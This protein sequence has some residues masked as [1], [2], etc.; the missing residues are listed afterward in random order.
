[1]SPGP[2]TP[3]GEE[4]RAEPEIL[5]PLRGEARGEAMWQSADDH[6]THRIYVARLG[7]FSMAMLLLAMALLA[8]ILVILLIG[9]ILI[10]IPVVAFVIAIAVV[11]AWWRGA[12]RR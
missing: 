2:P 1:M 11:S 5:P 4:P 6:G 8:A 10:W 7:P 12:F 3:S 9:T